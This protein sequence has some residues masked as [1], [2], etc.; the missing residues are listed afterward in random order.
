MDSISTQ[1][2]YQIRDKHTTVEALAGNLEMSSTVL[3]R[4]VYENKI[5]TLR[6]LLEIARGLEMKITIT[7]EDK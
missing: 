4:I 6:E 2:K 5:P 3:N 1:I 7:L